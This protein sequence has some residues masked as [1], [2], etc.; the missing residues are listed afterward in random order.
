MR[1]C[2]SRFC[3]LV[4]GPSIANARDEIAHGMGTAIAALVA[5]ATHVLG[6]KA[7]FD[8]PYRDSVQA[9]HS[10]NPTVFVFAGENRPR[11][12]NSKH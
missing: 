7:L 10:R 9:P 6:S 4:E 12:S 2:C 11:V 3:Y 1:A 5:N 8:S